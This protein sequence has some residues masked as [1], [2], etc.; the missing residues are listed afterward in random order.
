MNII[1]YYATVNII[2][3]IDKY[4]VFYRLIIMSIIDKD[5]KQ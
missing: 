1:K 5:I 3:N 2:I 4:Y